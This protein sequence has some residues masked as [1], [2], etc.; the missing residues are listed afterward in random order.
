[1]KNVLVKIGRMEK[2]E[3]TDQIPGIVI[4]FFMGKLVIIGE[5][6]TQDA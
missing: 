1:M 4:D 5:H 3:N 6:P 2:I